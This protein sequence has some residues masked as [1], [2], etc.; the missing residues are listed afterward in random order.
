MAG[1]GDYQRWLWIELIGFDNERARFGVPELLER[2]GFVPDAA[3]LLL[4]NPDFV[5]AHD[6]MRAD[7]AFPGDVCSYG[8]YSASQER[9]RQVWTKFQLRELVAEL[10]R[11]GVKVFPSVFDSLTEDA[12]WLSRHPELP[13]VTRTGER[14]SSL[15][16]RKRLA[17]GSFY[18]DFFIGKLL[19]VLRDYGFD[20]FF[21]ADGYNPPRLPVYEGDFSDDLVEQFLMWGG[22]TL[23]GTL[24]GPCDADPVRV[25]A[26][27]DWVWQERRRE[28]IDFCIARTATFWRKLV[29]ALHAEDK[30]V[31]VASTWTKDPFE[32]AYRFGVDYRTL[33]DA[34]VDG[35][36]L[37]AAAAAL[38]TLVEPDPC[39]RVLCSFASA[40]LL[41]K[42]CVPEMPMLW[43]HGVKDTSENWHALREA[44]MA[45]DS[46]IQAYTHLYHLTA[47]AG[48]RRCAEGPMVC[49]ADCLEAR[50]WE[51]LRRRWD[52]GFAFEP[53]RVLGAT[54]LW[55]ASSYERQIDDYIA[56][57][58][59]T[60][61]RL[62]HHLMTRGAAVHTVADV[63]DIGAVEGATLVLGAHLWRAAEVEAL[64]ARAAGPVVFIGGDEAPLPEPEFRVE[65]GSGPGQM[66]CSVYGI[67]E[68]GPEIEA[69]GASVASS[70]PGVRR[71]ERSDAAA[72]QERPRLFYEELAYR[73]VSER[74]LRDCVLIVNACARPEVR[75]TPS[76]GDLSVWAARDR[77]GGLRL[78]VRNDR[79]TQSR[80]AIDVGRPVR[81]VRRL[82]SVT[83]KPV[84]P[85]GTLI[86]VVVPAR[87]TAVFDVDL[88]P[89]GAEDSER[90]GL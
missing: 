31:F 65:D 26:R 64:L 10:H 59:W 74:F 8:G 9:E 5:H 76:A 66:V 32:S 14:K 72:G 36:V 62:L 13:W 51:W 57:G 1:S 18:E 63:G 87:G 49:L 3:A 89:S 43:L 7:R 47:A 39:S 80:G 71:A 4:F 61:H 69:I 50:E 22:A 81:D 78:L 44:P 27:A 56:T 68:D 30:S 38:E 17:D 60:V 45:L 40:V 41:N 70:A 84:V 20:G 28:W 75:V 77:R 21:G 58:R 54:L 53:E 15:C 34:G 55:S 16:P 85:R 33:A 83:G 19:E 25:E 29:A 35:F 23:P 52:A 82:N 79:Y 42:A 73:E 67:D 88:E 48:L 86:E 2:A 24:S 46:E 6:G 11:A 37:E 90:R 12:S